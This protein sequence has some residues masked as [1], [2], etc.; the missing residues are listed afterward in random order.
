MQG[1]LHDINICSILRL[2]E[3]E[4]KTGTLYVETEISSFNLP[5][6][7]NCN[8][9]N[10]EIEFLPFTK[11]QV[12][13]RNWF[14]FFFVGQIIYAT[15]SNSQD[16]L[17][18]KNYLYF[19]NK[20]EI[21][22]QLTIL[23]DNSTTAPEYSAILLLLQQQLLQPIQAQKIIQNIVK[24]S[25]FEL[26]ISNPKKFIFTSDFPPF[27]QITNL[28]ISFLIGTLKNQ[29]SLWKQFYPY[30][31]SPHQYLTI[32]DREQLR[33]GLSRQIYQTLSDWT[34]KKASLLELSRSINCSV[35]QLAKAIYPYVR[36]GWV[37]LSARERDKS[38][39]F[40]PETVREKPHII[41]IDNDV[42][43]GKKVE[44]ILK[45]KG[46]DLT[47]VKNSIEALSIILTIRPTLILCNIN[48]PQFSGYELCTM[49]QHIQIC[50]QIPII[51]LAD[52][53]DFIDRLKTKLVSATDYLTKPFTKNELLALVE[54]HLSSI[55]N[56]DFSIIGSSPV[57]METK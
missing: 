12:Q 42:T 24:E 26:L 49:L 55:K 32:G 18:L 5:Q 29:V 34:D 35:V 53:D 47:I 56:K 38:L 31:R 33:L 23:S 21:L 2:L 57:E 1:N 7:Q 28:R 19:D 52:R 17:R 54:K 50:Q 15:D 44:Y 11:T 30:I 20:N 3:F 46:Y 13:Q 43:N 39:G 14:I 22:E 45:Q 16:L 4:Q 9:I 8:C 51:M 6:K 37:K 27:P 36:K 10:T 25:L 48:M 40:F 41:C